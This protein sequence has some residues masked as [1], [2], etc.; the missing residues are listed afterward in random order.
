MGATIES[1]FG[2]QLTHYITSSFSSKRVTA[3]KLMDINVVSPLWIEQCRE[4]QCRAPEVD[5]CVNPDTRAAP[6]STATSMMAEHRG[7]AAAIP[8]PEPTKAYS[9][10]SIDSPHFSSSQR[11]D[12]PTKETDMISIPSTAAFTTASSVVAGSGSDQSNKKKK[13]KTASAV[14]AVGLRSSI[15]AIAVPVCKIAA[16]V[17]GSAIPLPT[18]REAAPLPLPS[19]EQAGAV[20]R[21]YDDDVLLCTAAQQWVMHTVVV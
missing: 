19:S 10:R 11:L 3:A 6:S 5:F 8:V 17:V 14:I 1:T 18:F 16:A 4:L 20:S 7:P 21:R 12:I 13:P 15:P 2:E 9:L